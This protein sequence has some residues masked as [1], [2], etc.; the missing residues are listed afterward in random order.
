[1]GTGTVVRNYLQKDRRW[2]IILTSGGGVFLFLSACPDL[3]L[4]S[5]SVGGVVV[6]IDNYNDDDDDDDVDLVV[7]YVD[8]VDLVVVVSSTCVYMRMFPFE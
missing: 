8:Y 5:P 3:L 1:M 4:C 2:N 6:V 7:V